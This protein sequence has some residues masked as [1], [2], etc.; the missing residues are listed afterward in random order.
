M[1]KVFFLEFT[2]HL[3]EFLKS[4]EPSDIVIALTPSVAAKLT[5][6]QIPFK[7]LQGDYYS[8]EEYMEIVPGW[9]ERML[10]I[11]DKLDEALWNNFESFSKKEITPFR[12]NTHLLKL[13]FDN[14]VMKIF[15]LEQFFSQEKIHQ[16]K[17]FQCPLS[18]QIERLC[19]D[20]DESVYEQLIYLMKNKY[21]YEISI[22]SASKS[23]EKR[24]S[25]K[26][27]SH[28]YLRSLRWLKRKLKKNAV[29]L[30]NAYKIRFL[31]Q[32]KG[33]ILNVN[34][35]EL[36]SISSPL[37]RLDWV[38]DDYPNDL[39]PAR[40]PKND[41]Y[42]RFIDK[43]QESEEL[44]TLFTFSGLNFFKL[45]QSKI[46]NF[47]RKLGNILEDYR[48]LEEYF[49]HQHCDIV[50][51]STHSPYDIQN[52]IIP[53]LCRKRNIPYVCWMHGGSGVNYR[54][55]YK[56]TDYTYGQHYFVYGAEVKK[57]LDQH[58]SQYRLTTHV[59]GS[60][61]L[62]KRQQDYQPPQNEKKII[63]L[64]LC[65]WGNNRQYM[66]SDIPQFRFSFWEPLETIIRLLI[67]YEKQYHIIVRA[68][69]NQSQIDTVKNLLS[70]C[71]SEG[72]EVSSFKMASFSEIVKRSDLFINTWVSTTFWE[73]CLS[74]ADIFVM[75][76]SD[77]TKSAKKL[78]PNRA[79]W[80]DDLDHFT[81]A[82]EHYLDEGNFYQKSGDQSF[83]N[84]YMDFERK[85]HIPEHVS[86]T[87]QNI[88][89]QN[90]R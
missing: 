30:V 47:C 64:V 73:E 90:S 35:H 28:N 72:I 13:L 82:L 33:R 15:E 46:H 76:N 51:F 19:Y 43:I 88:L 25:D 6:Y 63:T 8:H 32:S 12:W 24:V 4:R 61:R 89:N 14:I 86:Q 57:L 37:A 55:G 58:Y 38:I 87:I 41:E 34:C 26:K 69:S 17:I 1:A 74:H 11:T 48:H 21:Q 22:I 81:R 78:L 85:D 52:V 36:S 53:A 68:H 2:E 42:S 5:V 3:P 49:G 65:S 70:D 29:Q 75:D 54:T 80:Y 67:R 44:T 71:D 23:L 20:D 45:C 66:A 31:K 60:P 77:L 62:L 56:I 7:L 59:V 50:F 10:N 40:P 84:A 39:L 27:P 83:L 16:V 9:E 79:F 18:S